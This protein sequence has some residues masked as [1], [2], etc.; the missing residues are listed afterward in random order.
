MAA[1][2]KTGGRRRGTPNRITAAHVAEI[3]ASGVL[4]LDYM[5]EV[6]RDPDAEYARRD[7]M[8]KAA[9]PYV[10]SQLKA[11][12]H[13]GKDGGPIQM[14]DNRDLARRIALTLAQGEK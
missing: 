14:Y 5:L 4:P 13:T 8:A 7:Y 1:G 10:H 6:M 9:A 2:K 3:A 12:E 11:I